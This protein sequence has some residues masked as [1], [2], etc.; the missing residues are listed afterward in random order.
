M[1][2]GAEPPRSRRCAAVS[3][4]D[5][6][7]GR[8]RDGGGWAVRA[9]TGGGRAHNRAPAFGWGNG[10][11]DRQGGAA[12]RSGAHLE[13]GEILVAPSQPALDAAFLDGRECW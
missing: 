8:H 3:A 10:H 13:R 9:E 12:T 2:P 1:W 11:R 5:A 4:S 7:V 6:A